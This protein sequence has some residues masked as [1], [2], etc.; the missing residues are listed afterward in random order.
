VNTDI[1]EI[2][3][4]INESPPNREKPPRSGGAWAFLAMLVSLVALAGTAWLW[5]QGQF[6]QS[7][8]EKLLQSE[9]SRLDSANRELSS[10]LQ[11]MRDRIAA[12]STD[13]RSAAISA[14]ETRLQSE[15]AGLDRLNRSVTEQAALT[16]A[17]QAAAESMQGRLLAA[18]AAISRLSP[19]ELDAGKDLDLAEVDYLL[20]LANERLQLFLDPR[21]ADRALE[22]ADLHLDA[23]NNPL[24]LGVRQEIAAARRALAEVVW[25]DYFRI[26]SEIDSLQSSLAGLSFRDEVQAP[27]EPAAQT[28]DQGWWD[29]LKGVF[30]GLVT[31]RRST[32]RENER[33]SLEDRDF[34]RQRLWLELEIARLSLMRHDQPSFRQ[35][36]QRVETTLQ[37]WFDAGSPQFRSVQETLSALQGVEIEV[38]VPDITQPW[39]TFR[40]LRNDHAR[41][42]SPPVEAATADPGAE[43][44]AAS[45]SPAAETPVESDGGI[46]GPQPA[47]EEPAAAGE[48]TEETDPA[49]SEAAEEVQ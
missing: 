17:V 20:R 15:T 14:L 7:D 26:S 12:L 41:P 4:E 21:S 36:L 46:P 43:A 10:E 44:P 16:R 28:G 48:E 18:E 8:E 31:V 35:A 49:D 34:V 40:L 11:Q 19:V 29:K 24:Y 6:S 27:A 33:I 45:A 2:E 38:T 42:A 25:P 22:L 47:E 23:L 9:V 5:W 32:D 30:S 13:D 37:T 1:S 3:N 39:S